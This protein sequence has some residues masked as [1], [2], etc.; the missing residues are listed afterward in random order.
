MDLEH[1]KLLR[2]ILM[3]ADLCVVILFLILISSCFHR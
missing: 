2:G 3:S 1:K